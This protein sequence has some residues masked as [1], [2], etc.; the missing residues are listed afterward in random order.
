MNIFE[1][2]TGITGTLSGYGGNLLDLLKQAKEIRTKLENKG[3]LI[4]NYLSQFMAAANECLSFE[5]AEE[6]FES[7]NELRKLCRSLINNSDGEKIP[8]EYEFTLCPVV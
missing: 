7:S 2:I 6:G 4:D 1:K 3:Y 8:Y 5:V